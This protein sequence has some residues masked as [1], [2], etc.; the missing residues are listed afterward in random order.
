MKLCDKVYLGSGMVTHVNLKAA[1]NER[2]SDSNYILYNP[3]TL[4]SV[5]IQE[6]TR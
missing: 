2:W 4:R 6:V 3:A 5:V 1:Q